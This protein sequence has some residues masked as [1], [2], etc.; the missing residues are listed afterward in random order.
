MSRTYSEL[1]AGAVLQ[2]VRTLGRRIGERF[3]EAGLG[4]V[5]GTLEGICDEST[6]QLASLRKPIWPLRVASVTLL[7]VVA[8][9]TAGT[10]YMVRPSNQAFELATFVDMV[11][12]IIQDLVYLAIGVF[13]LVR[14]ET[15]IKR[16]RVSRIIHQLRSIAHVIDMHQLTKDPDRVLRN[17]D[18]TASSPTVSLTPFLLRRYLDYCSEMLSLTGKIAALYLKHFDDP[19]TVAAVTE[20]EDL[21]TGLSRKIWQKIIALPEDSVEEA[22]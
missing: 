16:R 20:I 19:A 10:I 3:P 1:D 11:Q 17:R 6:E 5:C 14:L 22:K 9:L 12:N 18:T 15:I 21:T 8:G 2:T 13:F 4:G 7:I